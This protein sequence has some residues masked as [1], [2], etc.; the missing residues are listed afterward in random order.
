MDIIILG[1]GKVGEA[2]AERLTEENHS[3]T[4]IDTRPG[5]IEKITENYDVM[6][7]VGNGSSINVLMEAGVD[8]CDVF[9]SVT[10]TDE[11]NLL[12]C[13]FAKKAGK[14][15][16]IARVR[17]PSYNKELEFIQQQMGISTI[18]N[19]ELATAREIY[20]LLMFPSAIKIEP[21]ANDKV[22]LIKFRLQNVSALGGMRLLDISEK[23]G[24]DIL[25]CC[26]ERGDNVMIPSGNTVLQTGD[27]VSFLAEPVKA[28]E[29]FEKIGLSTK[30]VRNSII[31]GGGTIGYY[32]ARDLIENGI[33]VRII[34][35][36]QERCEELAELL[37]EATVLKGDGTDRDL[38]NSEGLSLTDSFVSL[39]GL[40]EENVLLGLYANK[41]SKAKV[42][43]KVNRLEFDDILS[44]LNMDSV[45]YPKHITCDFIMQYVR[46][47]KVNAGNTLKT[48][49]RILADK[50]EA[51][52]FTITKEASYTGKPLSQLGLKKNQLIACITR[53]DKV[54]IPRG[55]DEIR[56]GDSVILVTLEH[57][58]DDFKDALLPERKS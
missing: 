41:H 55:Y 51:L 13:M 50:V 5:R 18:I 34:E 9:I 45:V 35:E 3:V 54:L 19:P 57:G 23:L 8:N 56:V 48:L 10:G 24:V 27:I 38:L 16:A 11:I 20:N 12:S 36:K 17:N 44:G 14:C 33:N 6:G 2:L 4:V 52:E 30:P 1:C 43:T 47:L 42:V 39:T 46:A 26:V 28:R 25:V 21:F 22:R 15:R 49:Y 31:V 37:P 29:F 32:L 53:K 7:I 40:D 58:L